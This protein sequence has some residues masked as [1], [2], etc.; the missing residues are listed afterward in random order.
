M[1]FEQPNSFSPNKQ[2]IPCGAYHESTAQSPLPTAAGGTA[3]AR[4]CRT[5]PTLQT[6]PHSYSELIERVARSV[7]EDKRLL[8]A[9]GRVVVVEI[10]VGRELHHGLLR[11]AVEPEHVLV[12]DDARVVAIYLAP[13]VRVVASLPVTAPPHAHSGVRAV[14]LGEELVGVV[15]V[16]GV[17]VDVEVVHG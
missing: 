12:L 16:L 15:G 10:E 2:C 1:F 8:A 14:R 13:S 7:G 17:G 11:D 5:S 9:V 4:P 3:S 6:P